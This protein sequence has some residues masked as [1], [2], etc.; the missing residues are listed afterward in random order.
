MFHSTLINNRIVE[1]FS[2][3]HS[4]KTRNDMNVEEEKTDEQSGQE[5]IEI[6]TISSSCSE[7]ILPA[8]SPLMDKQNQPD[9]SP[10]RSPLVEPMP[11]CSNSDVES[12]T[13]DGRP[14]LQ[15]SSMPCSPVRHLPEVVDQL[16]VSS[17]KNS[18]Q[19]S[20]TT[21]ALANRFPFNIRETVDWI[22]GLVL[23]CTVV[24]SPSH[25]EQLTSFTCLL[26]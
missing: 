22:I 23:F 21:T 25:R 3:P 8:K 14:Q 12:G 5:D 9:K 10:V 7:E 2:F 11:M 26:L 15:S 24:F 1:L 4:F 19:Q 18:P 20:S 17:S 16:A 13:N 6:C